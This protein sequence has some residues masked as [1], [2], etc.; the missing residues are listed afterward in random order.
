MSRNPSNTRSAQLPELESLLSLLSE[1]D[2]D[3]IH[4]LNLPSGNERSRSAPRDVTSTPTTGRPS[5]HRK[6][7]SLFSIP[8]GPRRTNAH[9]RHK[10]SIG[11]FISHSIQGLET[12]AEQ[13]QAE[14]QVVRTTWEHQLDDTVHG[15]R[16]FFDMS[17]TRSLS[18]LPESIPTLVE[19]TVGNDDMTVPMPTT[20]EWSIIVGRY[21]SLLAAVVAVSSNGS[22]VALLHGVEPALK[23]YWRMTVTAT[24][25]A[26]MALR[27]LCTKEEVRSFPPLLNFSQWLVFAGAVVCFFCMTFL[28]YA[29]LEYTSIGNAVIGANSQALLLIVG[30]ALVG[31]PVVVWE[32]TGVLLAFTG[33]ILCSSDEARTA[34]ST[35]DARTASTALFGDALALGS[36]FAGVGYLTFA[37]ALRPTMSVTVFMFLVM[38]G[39][40]CL[41]LLYLV[42]LGNGVSLS[43]DPHH[44]LW[45]WCSLVDAHIY[46]IAYI[47]IICNVIGTMGFVRAMQYF[48]TLIIAVATLLEPMIATLI[49]YSM[50]VGDL[51]GVLGWIGNA[52]V[53]V[54]TLAVVYPS[55]YTNHPTSDAITSSSESKPLVK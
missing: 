33:C 50:H 47:A 16:T 48:D 42:T 37:K 4:E 14:A 55:V 6:S 18:V 7:T 25:L 46:V 21:L 29:A 15:R 53:A 19:E 28:M 36:A 35:D 17:M 44:G 5:M 45:G 27:T 24:I 22:A 12:I 20:T 34:A 10:S 9:H 26:P 43:N 8:T 1:E 32:M 39:A 38:C 13:V 11:Q 31:E 23:L 30:K 3:A 51:P 49:A 52:M 40:S 2:E 54:G 41:V